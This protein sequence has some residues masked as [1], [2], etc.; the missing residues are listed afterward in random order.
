[1]SY[2]ARGQRPALDTLKRKS[3]SRIC[4][5]VGALPRSQ[6][7]SLKI[8]HVVSLMLFR[9]V[10]LR[11]I[12]T[13]CFVRI[14]RAVYIVLPGPRTKACIGYIKT[15]ITE[16]D[17]QY[18]R[19]AS[20]TSTCWLKHFARRFVDALPACRFAFYSVPSLRV[21]GSPAI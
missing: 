19:R 8:L 17:K 5:I 15:H 13:E 3:Q 7:A 12:L 1:M 21:D 4:S 18:C 10:G 20:E 14:D 16:Q 6:P 9:S 11:F 2:R